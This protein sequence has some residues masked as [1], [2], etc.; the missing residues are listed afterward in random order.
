MKLLKTHLLP[1]LAIAFSIGAT[2][3]LKAADAD[4]SSPTARAIVTVQAKHGTQ[5][6][7]LN[8]NDLF[9]YQGKQRAQVTGV[10]ALQGDDAG[11]QLF[12]YLDDS[13]GAS[14]LGSRLPELKTFIRSLPATTQV[15]IGYM[16]NGGFSLA[17]SFTTEHEDAVNALRLPMGTPG[18]NGS[19]YFALSYLVKH[20][21]SKERVQRRAVL[22]LTDGIDRYYNN[23]E[24][25]DPYVDAATKD[26]Q[27]LGVLVYSI[28]LH[29]SGSYPSRGG[30]ST[31]MAQSRLQE[32][33]NKTGG[34]CFLEGLMTPISLTP[35]L[36]QLSDRLANQYEVTFL[37]SKESGLQPVT[38]RSELPK[39]K[40]LAPRDVVV[41]SNAS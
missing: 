15:A 22:M 11:L 13:T 29:G 12:I 10:K 30:W 21:P 28:Y 6:A 17:Q 8:S 18:G 2:A 36:N 37:A 7:Q 39:I 35:Y 25:N 16:R 32:V 33:S 24:V 19:P 31:T 26:S 34:E 20:W 5:P 40:L 3:N 9:V 4:A 14:T 41:R 1:L 27:H 23:Y 38:I